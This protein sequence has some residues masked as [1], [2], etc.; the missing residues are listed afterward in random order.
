M[1]TP[2]PTPDYDSIVASLKT[3]MKNKPEY[4]DYDFDGS[5]MSS[6]IDLLSYN[7]TINAFYLNQVGNEAFLQTAVKKDSVVA[8]AQDFGYSV[9][10]SR[11]ARAVVYMTLTRTSGAETATIELPSGSVFNAAIGTKSF[12][13][14]TVVGHTLINNGSGQYSGNVEIY[15]GRYF[16]HKF[17]VTSDNQLNGF[18][19]PNKMVDDSIMNVFVSPV[20][21]LSIKNSYTRTDSIVSGVTPTSQ[22]YFVSMDRGSLTR[23]RFGDGIIGKLLSVGDVVEVQYLVSSGELANG[24]SSFSL[25]SVPTNTTATLVV[26][27]GAVGGSDGETIESIKF[28]APKY[29]ESQGRAVTVSDYQVLIRKIYS[30]VGD[31]IVWGGEDNTPPKY[32]KVIISIKPKTGYYMTDSEKTYLLALLKNYNVA[33][34]TPEIVDPDYMHIIANTTVSFD[35][36]ITNKTSAEISSIVSATI[37]SYNQTSLGKFSV[38]LE[39]SGLS[40]AI[41]DADS[42]IVSNKVLFTLEKRSNPV[43]GASIDIT[44][45]FGTAVKFGSL[46]SSEFVFNNATKCRFVDSATVG[47]I[48]LVSYQTGSKIIMKANAGTIDQ[49]TGKY[50]IV[51]VYLTSID[52]SNIDPTSGEVYFKLIS[53]ADSLDVDNTDRNILDIYASTV[54][55]IER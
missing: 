13:F 46:N 1:S 18:V 25:V 6:L 23:V 49:S 4:A 35:K 41:L 33:T 27:S 29:F 7:S 39:Y 55:V 47:S 14:R 16:S 52:S 54:A 53:V 42:S 26:T 50:S 11:S 38:A 43:V 10:S 17:T 24:I 15:E 28:N 48:D 44:G 31:V 2:I 12:T 30:N 40:T 5:M 9:Q 36:S 32:G 45:T 20:S 21:N 3:F 22:V 19:L 37:A 8:N 51:D 34:V